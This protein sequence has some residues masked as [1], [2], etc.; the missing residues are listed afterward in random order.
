MSRQGVGLF[1][2]SGGRIYRRWYLFLGA[3][4]CMAPVL[5]AAHGAIG[6]YYLQAD[7]IFLP[8][9]QSVAGN[10]LRGEPGQTVYFTAMIDRQLA[11]EDPETGPATT[12]APLYATGIREAHSTFLP[13]NGGQWQTNFNR[14][15]ITVE[16][17]GETSANVEDEFAS[18]LQRIEELREQPQADM[19]IA[20][21]SYITTTL[22]PARP[23]MQYI[24]VR[25]KRA[26]FAF[27]MVAIGV[28]TGVAIMGDQVLEFN[29]RRR[30]RSQIL[31]NDEA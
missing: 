4:L 3:L 22:S 5:F 9:P 1:R 23:K 18:I 27:G 26:V 10:S 19:H 21:D 14:P 25:S 16:V 24:G 17:V 2:Q 30:Q 6:V 7:V 29:E 31:S 28:S 13:N 12:D 15:V 8:P 11:G 20:A